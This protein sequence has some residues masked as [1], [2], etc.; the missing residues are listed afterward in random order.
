MRLGNFVTIEEAYQILGLSRQAGA[1]EAKAAYRKLALDWH[2]DRAPIEGE[3]EHFTARFK[4]IR[5]AYEF[6]RQ[7]SFPQLPQADDFSPRV[8]GRS[9]AKEPE[10]RTFSASMDFKFDFDLRTIGL[11]L[12]YFCAAAV[13][14]GLI[15]WFGRTLSH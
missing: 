5:D 11:A 10:I 1:G 6:L 8:G 15:R 14:L 7:A 13:L 4:E 12:L 3:R 9:F 2:P